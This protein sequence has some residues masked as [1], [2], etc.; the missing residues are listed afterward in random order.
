MKIN[1][2][3]NDLLNKQVTS[4]LFSANLYMSAASW[5]KVNKFNG[6]AA[7]L[8]KHGKEERSHADAFM[9]FTNE[10][11]GCIEFQMVPKPTTEFK[12]G[13]REIFQLI[14]AHEDKVTNQINAIAELCLELKDH[15][16]YTF[17]QKYCAEQLE[18]MAIA[19]E[20]L[21]YLA[22]IEDFDLFLFDRELNSKI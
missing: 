5:C 16:T 22:L 9:E 2:K 7:W 14:A 12:K 19:R 18:E 1:E 10:Y 8:Y 15:S 20:N 11:G 17:V 21:D 13:I 6:V 4:E 3:I